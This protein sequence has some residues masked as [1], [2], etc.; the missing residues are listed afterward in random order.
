MRDRTPRRPVALPAVG[1]AGM[2]RRRLPFYPLDHVDDFEQQ[3]AGDRR[4]LAQLHLD[5][6]A[7]GPAPAAAFPDQGMGAVVVMEILAAQRRHGHQP[8]RPRLVQPD[9][10]AEAGDAGDASY[11]FRSRR[12]SGLWG[13]RDAAARRGLDLRH[14][15]GG[16]GSGVLERL[17]TGCAQRYLSPVS[18]GSKPIRPN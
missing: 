8:V 13:P 11:S 5:H 3:A 7:Q 2:P 18:A 9:E 14:L 4:R 6:A 10:Q 15:R 16:G 17:G 1:R 12:L